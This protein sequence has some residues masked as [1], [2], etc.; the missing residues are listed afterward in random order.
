L[1]IDHLSGRGK[2]RAD[3]TA[4][5]GSLDALRRGVDGTLDVSLA[6][7]AISGFDMGSALRGLRANLMQIAAGLVSPG[8]VRGT[9]FSDLSAHLVLHDGVAENHDLTGHAPFMNFTGGGKLDL[10]AGTVDYQL[11]AIL[12]GG[13][14]VAA[15]D[16]LRGTV[17]PVQI[18]G[19][20]VSPDYRVDTTDLKARLAEA[21]KRP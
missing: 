11:R 7:G 2:L 12:A 9:R 4:P 14:G 21:G 16:A 13:S 1:G 17:V 19:R 5:L 20:L 15:L 18:S 10:A 3:L 8:P 6:K